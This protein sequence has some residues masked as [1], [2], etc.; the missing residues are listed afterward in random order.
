MTQKPPQFRI[1]D[2]SAWWDNFI[3]YGAGVSKHRPRLAEPS[4]L[5]TDPAAMAQRLVDRRASR[6]RGIV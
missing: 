4:E 2:V 5:L 1:P 6:L 3:A